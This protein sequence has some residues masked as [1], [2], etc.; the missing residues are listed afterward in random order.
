MEKYRKGIYMPGCNND[1]LRWERGRV[2]VGMTEEIK[3][4]NM[5]PYKIRSP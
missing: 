4:K 2:S 1:Y 5:R 3:P